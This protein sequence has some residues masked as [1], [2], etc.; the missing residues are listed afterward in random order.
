MNTDKTLCLVIG[1]LCMPLSAQDPLIR[2]RV[3]ATDAP[4]RLLHVQM[5]VPA[6]PGPMTLVYPKWIP[7]E[8]MPTGPITDL[9]GLRIQAGGQTIPWKRDNVNM[10]AFHIQ[11][12]AGGP[13]HGGRPP[14][15][16]AHRRRQRARHRDRA[17]TSGAVQESGRGNRCALRVAALSRLSL[18]AD[19][20]RSCGALRSGAP[21]VQ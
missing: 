15:L 17:G 10:Y 12:P 19:A 9:A 7:G 3:D 2:I 21:R 8:H 11:A 18:S 6:K 14:D 20:Q 5:N 16:S 13:G 4:R 1:V